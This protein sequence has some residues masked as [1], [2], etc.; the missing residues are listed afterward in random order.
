MGHRERLSE[1]IDSLSDQHVDDPDKGFLGVGPFGRRLP[2]D[3][4]LALRGCSAPHDAARLFQL[5]P[6]I[7]SIGIVA[8]QIDD[9]LQ[10]VTIGNDGAE[11][12]VDQA[13]LDAVTLGPPPILRQQGAGVA[14]PSLV[15]APKPIEHAGQG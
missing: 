10:E 8:G 14:P 15:G 4:A 2:V 3:R 11:A 13:A 5:S 1:A 12:E 9:L 7:E 6:T